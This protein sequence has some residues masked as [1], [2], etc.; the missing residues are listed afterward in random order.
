MDHLGPIFYFVVAEVKDKL[1]LLGNYLKE[2][3]ENYETIEKT[4]VYEKDNNLH[5]QIK[6]NASRTI[7][8]LHRA[9]LF[10]YKFLERLVVCPD[11][12]I[13]SSALCIEVYNA[14]LAKVHI[15]SSCDLEPFL[16]GKAFSSIIRGLRRKEPRSECT[17][18]QDARCLLNTC[19]EHPT[20]SN[21]F[22]NSYNTSTRFTI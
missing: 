16:I 17:R 12:Q 6:L 1:A 15:I 9:L 10:I 2:K 14:T 20:I 4:V 13:K 3:P 22:L 11:S 7:L 21:A 8:R 19:V 5:V 18:C